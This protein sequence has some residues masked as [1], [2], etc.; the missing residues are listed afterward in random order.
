VAWEPSLFRT[1]VL[2]GFHL[3]RWTLARVKRHYARRFR[4]LVDAQRIAHPAAFF[5][6]AHAGCVDLALLRLFLASARK[7]SS[8]ADISV[9]PKCGIPSGR[10]ECLPHR[11]KKCGLI[12]IALHPGTA[13]ADASAVQDAD[14]WHDPLA[15]RRP[16]ELQML[17]S[18]ELPALLESS[19][20]RLGRLK[21]AT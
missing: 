4:A 19:G 1:T 6:T 10:Q 3:G 16:G 11:G 2:S 12:E 5:G 8:G 18:P 21:L 17:V 14:G 15:A 13:A 9:C 20:W 7:L